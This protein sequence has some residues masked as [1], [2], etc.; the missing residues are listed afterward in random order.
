MT[1]EVNDNMPRI[2]LNSEI[3]QIYMTGAFG[4]FTAHDFRMI[5]FNEKPI[6]EKDSD[7]VDLVRNAS[8]EI[9]MSLSATKELYDWLGKNIEDYENKF[10][11]IKSKQPKDTEK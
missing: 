5:I 8:H 11:E 10:G 9:I 2:E 1:N 4:G 7:M 6:M 3:K